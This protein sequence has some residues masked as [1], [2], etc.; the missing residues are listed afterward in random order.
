M[1]WALL[2]AFLRRRPPWLQAAMVGLCSGIF[3]VANV[4][5]GQRDLRPGAAAAFVLAVAVP[6]GWAFSRALRAER[7]RSASGRPATPRG[8]AAYAAVWLVAVT[9]VVGTLLGDG[10]VRVA[11]IAIVPIVLLAPPAVL[12]I[13]ALLRPRADGHAV[14]P[15]TP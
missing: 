7:H 9:A 3:V 12:G 8:H 15:V 5:A 13:R 14:P 2:A 6:L 4:N 1:L 11:V 10:G